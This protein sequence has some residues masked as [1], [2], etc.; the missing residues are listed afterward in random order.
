M[1][2]AEGGGRPAIG[3]RGTAT[4]TVTDEHTARALGSGHVPVFSTPRLVALCEA[5]AVNALEGRLDPGQTSVGTRIEISH[6]AA[7]PVGH[8][9][10]AEAQITA[11]DGR[12]M[13][14]SVAAWD[15]REKI[16]EGTHDRVVIDERRF[17][18]RVGRKGD[19]TGR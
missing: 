12:W 19:A 5:A 10:R 13:R 15:A 2:N 4:L 18:E 6:L 11:I 14:F 7:T 17:M 9:V 1:E 8:T 16:G 3:L